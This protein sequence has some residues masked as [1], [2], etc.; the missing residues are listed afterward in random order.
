MCGVSGVTLNAPKPDAN[1]RKDAGER[2][3]GM[4]STNIKPTSDLNPSSNPS[5]SLADNLLKTLYTSW[6]LSLHYV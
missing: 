3:E 1:P 2:D 6:I 4:T 5:N